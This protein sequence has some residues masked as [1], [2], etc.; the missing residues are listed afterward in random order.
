MKTNTTNLKL[1]HR[2]GTYLT[3]G[4]GAGVLGSQNSNAAIVYWD[5]APQTISVGGTAWVQPLTGDTGNGFDDSTPTIGVRF[6]GTNYIYSFTEPSGDGTTKIAYN[7]GTYNAA[8]S[9][10]VSN[11]TIGVGSTFKQNWSYMDR[12]GWTTA[13]SAWATEADGTSGYIG[14]SFDNSGTTNYG[15]IEVT[16]NAAT[17]NL[18]MGDFAYEDSGA[19]ILAGATGVPEPSC[20]GLL[21]L[22][23]TGLL[24]RRRRQAA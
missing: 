3:L 17:G 4:V 8:M 11:E 7:Y 20:L 10:F 22:G 18:V 24:A 9:R 19:G 15:W 12:S 14:F 6:A 13:D 16:Y 1:D 23:A 21:A 5:V 2:L